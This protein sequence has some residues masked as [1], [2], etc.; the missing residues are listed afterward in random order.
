[1]QLFTFWQGP[2]LTDVAVLCLTSMV[3]AGHKVDLFSFNEDLVVP[4]GITLRDAREILPIDKLT[5]H[6][7]TGS[8]AL[9]SDIFRYQGLRQSAGTWVD[10][11][12]L[13]IKN[14]QHMGEYV[15]GWED[16]QSI[17]CAVLRMP[18]NS[19]CLNALCD[20]S[21]S[22]VVVPPFW[23]LNRQTKQRLRWLVGKDKKLENLEWGVIGPKAMTHFVK[24]QKLLHYT[25]SFDVFYPVH[26]SEVETF[27]S[28]GDHVEQMFTS[29]TRA[30][31]LWT[32]SLN[33]FAIRPAP[34]ECYL[35]RMAKKFD[36]KLFG[37]I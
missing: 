19:P 9:F 7:R 5:V 1:M 33:R 30:V 21:N 27:W 18:P 26:F 2:S 29:N 4:S 11:D 23:N 28:P 3:A 37:A 34:P 8:F 32:S 20:F 14:L 15:F 36:L 10:T 6:R 16:D 22:K 31:H 13:I 35:A 24:A 12:I 25:Q 17:N